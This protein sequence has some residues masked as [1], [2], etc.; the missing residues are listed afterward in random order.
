MDRLWRDPL[1]AQGAARPRRARSSSRSTFAE[2]ARNTAI[3]GRRLLTYRMTKIAL[4]MFGPVGNFAARTGRGL[5]WHSKIEPYLP[6]R[7]SGFILFALATGGRRRVPRAAERRAGG[8]DRRGGADADRRGVGQHRAC[9]GTICPTATTPIWSS[10]RMTTSKVQRRGRS[11]ASWRASLSRQPLEEVAAAQRDVAVVAA[12][13]GLRAGRD[14]VALG[15]DAQVHRR[16]APALAHRLQFDQRVGE[17][18]QG[19]RAGEEIAPEV[20]AQAVAE[21]RDAELVGDAAQ[22]QDMVAGQELRLVDQQAVEL[23]LDQLARRS[24]RTG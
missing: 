2:V 4:T 18:E 16:L 10:T 20:G 15:V 12:D 1:V 3:S 9:C 22:L 7:L 19:R 8:D 14:G 11:S 5:N 23:A 6:H 17:R 21:H 13:L 24:R